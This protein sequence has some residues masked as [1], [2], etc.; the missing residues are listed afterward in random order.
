MTELKNQEIQVS[1]VEEPTTEQMN[2][3]MTN[4]LV[5]VETTLPDPGINS[6]KLSQ[7]TRIRGV[8]DQRF[9]TGSLG[10]VEVTTGTVYLEN[11]FPSVSTGVYDLSSLRIAAGATLSSTS[12]TSP[13]V[14]KVRDACV[15]YGTIDF[16]NL[17]NEYVSSPVPIVN[18]FG[19]TCVSG[20][21]GQGG[22]GGI[23][24]NSSGSQDSSS[25]GSGALGCGGGG[26]G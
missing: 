6:D 22:K 12:S 21:T 4:L 25:G 16:S 2:L 7:K 23:N 15:L 20:T 14:L 18:P 10:N 1:Q 8:V 19:I 26:A 5:N 17:L 24:V 13:I 11:L 3:E 9:G